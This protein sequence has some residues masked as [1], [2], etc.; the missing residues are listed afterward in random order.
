M[1]R[2]IKSAADGGIKKKIGFRIESGWIFLLFF[3]LLVKWSGW[4]RA[5]P[6]GWSTEGA[7][8]RRYPADP[9]SCCWVQRG[10]SRPDHHRLCH[11][12][13]SVTSTTLTTLSYRHSSVAGRVKHPSVNRSAVHYNNISSRLV[14]PCRS[15]Q[16]GFFKDPDLIEG[17]A[18]QGSVDHWGSFRIRL[19]GLRIINLVR[20]LRFRRPDRILIL[21]R[22]NSRIGFKELGFRWDCWPEVETFEIL[23]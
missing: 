4:K 5:T 1:T 13:K 7:S 6:R 12:S 22:G 18:A 9:A 15:S 17:Q 10:T 3:N 20:F 21:L 11:R 19:L 16:A 8:L 2:R 23:I 14:D